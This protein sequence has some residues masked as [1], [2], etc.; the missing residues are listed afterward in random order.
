MSRPD[1]ARVSR[2]A[3]ILLD[4]RKNG[5]IEALPQTLWPMG[6]TEAY[7]IQAEV[8][9]S[10]GK[11]GGFK[12][13]AA[14]PTS[15]PSC[16]P[17]FAAGIFESPAMLSGKNFTYRGIES[18]IA[19]VLSKDLPRRLESY[20]Y[21]E[22]VD[23]IA[24]A[25]AGIEILQSRFC[26]PDRADPLCRLADNI[27]H[28][29]YILGEGRADWRDIDF[30]ALNICQRVGNTEMHRQGNPAG[31]MMR[32]IIWLANQGSV[33]FGGLYAGQVITC[34]SWT[35]KTLARPGEDAE[36]RF[37]GFAPVTVGFD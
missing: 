16:A 3:A 12:V 33:P 1:P 23:A 5:P 34:G 29:A 26:D 2:A 20:Q 32:L 4:A 8:A 15:H 17:I 31:D 30:A 28:G 14:G 24:T 35:G 21:D 37:D 11:I 9:A 6:E 27:N 7:A 19:F 10:I 13:G 25:H 18:E 36:A 22:V